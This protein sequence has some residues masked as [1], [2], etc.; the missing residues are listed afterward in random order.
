MSMKHSFRAKRM[1]RQVKQSSLNLTSLMD[2]FTILVFFL[3]V[4]SSDV[5]IV[6]NTDTITMPESVADK[7]PNMNALLIQVDRTN[8]TIANKVIVSIVDVKASKDDIITELRDAFL[9]ATRAGSEL[10]EDEKIVGRAV[11]I[12][13]DQKV[14]Y[15]VLRKLMTTAAATNYRNISLAVSQVPVKVSDVQ[16]N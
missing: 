16:E 9:A 8:I 13:G 4:N 7:A 2:I 3:M 6:K 12:Q 11:T 5:Q 1:A 15:I 10:T 14:P